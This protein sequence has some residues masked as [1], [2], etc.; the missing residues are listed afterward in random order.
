[1]CRADRARSPG[2]GD[3]S[4][5]ICSWPVR[6]APTG[7]AH[8]S[9]GAPCPLTPTTVLHKNCP[10]A[11]LADK[12]DAYDNADFRCNVRLSVS[13]GASEGTNGTSV[14]SYSL[15]DMDGTLV[16]STAGVIGAWE[17]FKEKYPQLDVTQVLSG[18]L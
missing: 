4:C 18:E 8:A 11:S 10:A 16:D 7:T 5:A 17:L 1:M 9:R 3:L 2:S 13:Y 12:Q 14:R 6:E 15:F